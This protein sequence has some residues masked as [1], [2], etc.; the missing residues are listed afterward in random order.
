MKKGVI[1]GVLMLG[2]GISCQNQ[3]NVAQ[4]EE[5]N[6]SM[7][8]V[9]EYHLLFNGTA[10]DNSWSVQLTDSTITVFLENDQSE[11]VFTN[12]KRNVI[13]DVA[14]MGYHATDTQ[15]HQISLEVF[16]ED[17]M[18]VNDQKHTFKCD[19][20]FTMKNHENESQ[21]T[22]SGCGDYLG[23]ERLNKNW[24]VVKFKGEPVS[25]MNSSKV[26]VVGF[27]TKKAE[28]N[29]NMGCNGIGGRYSLMENSMFFSPNFMS[30]QMYCEGA[31]EL[32]RDF[33][34]SV[35][36]KTLQYLFRNDQLIF[37][38]MDGVEILILQE[39]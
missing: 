4:K 26:P 34:K 12:V 7:A 10:S 33:T 15:G 35:S 1:I 11:L 36:G 32:E 31:M 30:T 18:D 39:N 17:C 21:I 38:T 22:S 13:M 37:K 6:S 8:Q 25:V 28:V 20:S 14:G 5:I 27:K 19:V 24:H 29:A 23:D 9:E 2:L 3:K 16:K